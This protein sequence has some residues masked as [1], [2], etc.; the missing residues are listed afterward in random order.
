MMSAKLW[1]PALTACA[2]ATSSLLVGCSDDKKAQQAAASQ[3]MPPPEVGVLI[4]QPQSANQSVQLSGRTNAYEVSEVRPQTSGIIL[5][6]LFTEGSYV[7]E[8]QALYEIDPRTNQTAVDN[9]KAEVQRQQANLEYLRVTQNRYKQLVGINAIS[10]QEYDDMT[11]QVKLAEAS[12]A[13]SQA[14]LKNAQINL[15][16]TIVRAPISGQ[17]NRS[18]VTAGALVTANQDSPLV[19]IQ[20]LDPIYVDINQS[21]SE[22]LRLRQQ[23]SKGNLDSSNDTK[24]RLKLEDG[25]Y[26]PV[27]GR[28]AF[29]D[30][31]VDENTGTI[32]L[33]AVFPNEN[34]LLLPGMF[35]NAEIIQSVIPNA[36]IIP[37]VAVT[38]TPTGQAMV[39]VVDAEGKAI[40]KP[41]TT[42]GSQ[43]SNWIISEGLQPGDKVIVD[44]LAKVQPNAKVTV[45]PYQPKPATTAPT[46][47]A[48]GSEQKTNAST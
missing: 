36:Y 37:Q 10:K 40:S 1:V 25:S 6:R 31:S 44:G 3:K 21:S 14:Q 4:A 42:A 8:G 32:T 48:N 38:R 17:S 22:L 11:S 20:R 19:K 34:N 26:Y 16:Y 23:L 43:G 13:S 7:R 5:K 39:M 18:L 35:V 45:K 28:L 24:V 30:V 9:A 2:L 41:V 46:N 27:E 29:S 33:R 15:G 12:L 47:L